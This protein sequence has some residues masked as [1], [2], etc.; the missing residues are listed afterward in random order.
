M[1]RI[2]YGKHQTVWRHG[3]KW[4]ERHDEDDGSVLFRSFIHGFALGATP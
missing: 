1:Y 4:I 2:P 3:T